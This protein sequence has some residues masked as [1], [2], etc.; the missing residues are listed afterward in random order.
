MQYDKLI[1]DYIPAIISQS[2]RRCVTEVLTK[3]AFRQALRAKL[4]EEAQ[5]VLVADADELSTELADVLEV[6]DALLEA[7]GLGLDSIRQLQQVRRRER[8]G[9]SQRLRLMSVEAS[10]Q[11]AE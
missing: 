6:L 8:G 7:H 3:P 5:E 1:R 2:G 10:Q 4:V 11:S 9:F